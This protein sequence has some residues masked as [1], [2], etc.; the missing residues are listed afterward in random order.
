MV[1]VWNYANTP[2]SDD[3]ACFIKSAYARDLYSDPKYGISIA[4]TLWGLYENVERC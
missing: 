4:Q 1:I 2:S 3:A